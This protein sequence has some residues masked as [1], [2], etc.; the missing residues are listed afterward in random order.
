MSVNR[1]TTVWCDGRIPAGKVTHVVCVEWRQES[2]NAATVRKVARADGWR[3][4]SDGRDLCPACT[5]REKGK[6]RPS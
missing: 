1:Q 5:E 2:G 4:K 3:R 6:A